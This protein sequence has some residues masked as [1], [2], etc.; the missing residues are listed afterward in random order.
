MGGY[1]LPISLDIF[2]GRYRDSFTKP[3]AIPSGVTQTYKFRLPTVNHVFKPGHRIMIQI[4]SSLFPLYER[5][6]QTFV[7]NIF[8]ATPED[9]KKEEITNQPGGATHGGG[10]LPVV[11]DDKVGA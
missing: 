11:G 5:N 8:L 10:L 9:Y 6:P 7:P 4:Q 3:T 2:R 1:Q